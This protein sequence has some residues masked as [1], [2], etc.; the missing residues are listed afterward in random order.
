MK[1]L[2]PMLNVVRGLARRVSSSLVRLPSDEET[3][4]LKFLPPESDDEVRERLGRLGKHQST[5]FSTLTTTWQQTLT[6]TAALNQ[7][8]GNYPPLTS[9]ATIAKTF[10]VGTSAANAAAGGGDLFFSFYQAITA[11]SSATINLASMTDILQ[12][13]T[14]V[15]V[16]LKQMRVRLLSAADDSTISPAPTATST[17]TVTNSIAGVPSPFTFNNTGISGTVTLTTSTGAVTGVAIGAA[18]TLYPKSSFFLAAPQQAA[19]SGCVFLCTVNSSGVISAVTFISGAGG[20]GYS[21]ATVPLIPVG[22]QELT[23]GSSA[24]YGDITAA[25]WLLPTS[26]SKNITILN[27][28]ASNAVTVEVSFVGGSS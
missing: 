1:F 14:I 21:D 19:G 9:G 10:S 22:Q 28:D 20:S 12:R 7:T 27:G 4:A 18:G 24:M 25:G 16:R 6:W 3:L 2:G 5:G 8:G 17:V 23:T 15:P 13:A 11:G 26:T